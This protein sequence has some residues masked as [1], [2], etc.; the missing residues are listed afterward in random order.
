MATELIL[1]RHGE[2]LGNVARE[3]RRGGRQPR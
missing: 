1:V 3:R 2:S